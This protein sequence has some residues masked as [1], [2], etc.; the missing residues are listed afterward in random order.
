MCDSRQQQQSQ[1][2]HMIWQLIRI[3][4]KEYAAS[5]VVST[6]FAYAKSH[7]LLTVFWM[8]ANRLRLWRWSDC[9]AQARDCGR[10]V[11]RGTPRRTRRP[12]DLGVAGDIYIW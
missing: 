12:R 4:L 6:A 11:S 3:T 7:C 8:Q 9:R 5:P 2:Q 10:G 1:Q